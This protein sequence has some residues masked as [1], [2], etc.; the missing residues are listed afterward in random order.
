MWNKWSKWS[1]RSWSHNTVIQKQNNTAVCKSSL[2]EET[3]Y[4]CQ[5]WSLGPCWSG[6]FIRKEKP[7]INL[8]LQMNE[9]SIPSSSI[10]VCGCKFPPWCNLRLPSSRILY[11]VG[12]QVP[13]KVPEKWRLKVLECILQF[14]CWERSIV[15]HTCMLCI[16]KISIF[17]QHFQ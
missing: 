2:W 17:T 16:T 14:T 8:L 13:H 15:I 5:N 7:I 6:L 11:V 4:E 9:P 3:N 10:R 1:H 12:R